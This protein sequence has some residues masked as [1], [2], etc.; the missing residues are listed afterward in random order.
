MSVGGG[1]ILR[2][3]MDASSVW[4]A[5]AFYCVTLNAVNGTAAATGT[6]RA[7]FQCH[8][9]RWFMQTA[10]V[11]TATLGD[12]AISPSVGFERLSA[13][14]FVRVFDPATED[15]FSFRPDLMHASLFGDTTSSNPLTL[16]EYILW[17]PGSLIG[18]EWTGINWNVG[19][20]NYKFLT[21]LGIEYGMK[22]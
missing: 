18:V 3:V 7:F 12:G 16:P 1:E 2:G 17:E 13:A 9:D 6:Q 11:A 20:P 5:P 4:S 14:E 15:D 19:V 21:L 22:G 8:K 10:M